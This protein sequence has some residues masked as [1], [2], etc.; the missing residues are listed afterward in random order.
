M[1]INVD[2]KTHQMIMLHLTPRACSI[3]QGH[4]IVLV[5]VSPASLASSA[6]MAPLSRPRLMI[7]EIITEL[8]CLI[9]S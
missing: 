3:Y 8:G 1:E 5:K 9:V 6:V 4:R 2:W 7:A